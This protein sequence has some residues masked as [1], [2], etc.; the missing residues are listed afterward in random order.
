MTRQA[1][2]REV[3]ETVRERLEAGLDRMDDVTQARL[4][5][6]RRQAL[7]AGVV[8]TRRRAAGWA[9][10]AAVV[11]AVGLWVM[12]G[13]GELPAAGVE[14]IEV[15]AAGDDLELYEDLEF[16]GWLASLDETG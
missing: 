13:R 8:H 16:Y 10:A 14:D 6:A 11:L 3:M 9:M 7:A 15:L 2:D 5:A 4:R 1:D 12:H